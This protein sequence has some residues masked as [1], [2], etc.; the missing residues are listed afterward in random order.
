[1]GA[2]GRSMKTNHP[3][4]VPPAPVTSS[5]AAGTATAGRGTRGPEKR[6]A[7]SSVGSQGVSSSKAT[8]KDGVSKDAWVAAAAGLVSAA[9]LDDKYEEGSTGGNSGGNSSEDTG[10]LGGLAV[11]TPLPG[12]GQLSGGVAHG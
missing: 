11:E 5:H 7:L 6:D 1:L 12:G 9:I 8:Q 3:Q 4:H 10:W 2:M